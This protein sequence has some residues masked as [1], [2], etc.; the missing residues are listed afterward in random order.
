[1]TAT[2][3]V[4]GDLKAQ[5]VLEITS[6]LS[7]GGVLFGDGIEADRLQLDWGQHAEV[8]IADRQLRLVA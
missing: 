4:E 1:T 2:T 5:S 6:E 3:L 7:D 8:G